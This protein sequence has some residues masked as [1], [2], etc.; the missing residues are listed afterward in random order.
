MKLK[1]I[2]GLCVMTQLSFAQIT[3]NLGDFDEVK[4]F[5]RINLELIPSSENKIVI[6]GDKSDKVEVIN[7]N[8][9]LIVRMPTVKLLDGDGI[10]AK[11][12]FRTLDEIEASE[13]SYIICDETLDQASIEVTTREGA[14]IKLK[15]NVKK[16]ESKSVTGGKLKLTGSA[17]YHEASLGTGG[18]LEAQ[19]LQTLQT[20]IK[21][22]TGGQADIRASD[23]VDAKVRAG[24]DITVFG[25]PKSV[26]KDIKLGGSVTEARR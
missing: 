11:L 21:I 19:N 25:A 5:D 8:G 13:G 12:Y 22:T 7:K 2:I 9:D 20:S 17:D 18:I 4:V 6:T 24:G 16:L 3:K 14:E 23:L 10:T 15:L 26:K 1:M